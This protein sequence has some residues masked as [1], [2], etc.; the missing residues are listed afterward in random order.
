MAG[1]V[2]RSHRKHLVFVATNT[3]GNCPEVSLQISSGVTLRN[4]VTQSQTAVTGLAAFLPN[5]TNLPL[6]LKV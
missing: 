5:T 3:A 1:D 6:Q 2:P 4:V